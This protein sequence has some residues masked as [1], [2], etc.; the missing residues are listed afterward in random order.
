MSAARDGW[1]HAEQQ[2]SLVNERQR[3][4]L[5]MTTRAD[6]PGDNGRARDLAAGG[7]AAR[8]VVAPW[9]VLRPGPPSYSS[10]IP[11]RTAHIVASARLCAP[12]FA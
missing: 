12:V 11:A 1:K 2:L 9:L 8:Q 5:D 7:E 10:T 6:E 4:V 3:Q